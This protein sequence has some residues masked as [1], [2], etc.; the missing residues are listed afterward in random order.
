MISTHSAVSTVFVASMCP[1]RK[2]KNELAYAVADSSCAPF[3]P[4]NSLASSPAKNTAPAVI[5]AAGTRR[6]NTEPGAIESMRYA[7]SGRTGPWSA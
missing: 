7:S 3:P 5:S 6:A 2:R 4:P 1:C